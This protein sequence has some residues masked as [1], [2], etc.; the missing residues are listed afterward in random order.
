M[1][2][3][4]YPLWLAHRGELGKYGDVQAGESRPGYIKGGSGREIRT[5]IKERIREW[6][7]N[8]NI[9]YALEQQ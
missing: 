1:P 5:T 7:K 6:G 4:P 8:W 9:Y 3:S 2:A